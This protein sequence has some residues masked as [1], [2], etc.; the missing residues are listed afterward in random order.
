MFLRP[1]HNFV[2]EVSL[3]N[4]WTK[5]ELLGEEK[6]PMSLLSSINSHNPRTVTEQTVSAL[7]EPV[8]PRRS[9]KQDFLQETFLLSTPVSNPAEPTAQSDNICVIKRTDHYSQSTSQIVQPDTRLTTIQSSSAAVDEGASLE[10]DCLTDIPVP[11]TSAAFP[12]GTPEI[13]AVENELKVSKIH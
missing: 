5:D 7:K 10:T 11:L 4:Q 8:P 12:D 9:K 1:Q 2:Q 3:F 13:E 6:P